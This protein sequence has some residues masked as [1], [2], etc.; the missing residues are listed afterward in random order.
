MKSATLMQGKN[1]PLPAIA[2][3]LVRRDHV[4]S[5]IVNANYSIKSNA[6]L[7]A[8]FHVSFH[9]HI[10]ACDFLTELLL[11]RSFLDLAGARIE[12]FF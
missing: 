4:A 1:S 7:A 5:F 8:F 12:R 3:V 2:L 10:E 6:G 11:D 9:S